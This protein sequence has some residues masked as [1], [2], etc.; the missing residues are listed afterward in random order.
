MIELNKEYSLP[1]PMFMA[2]RSED[3]GKWLCAKDYEEIGN[4]SIE[5]GQRVIMPLGV[6]EDYHIVKTWLVDPYDCILTAKK[7]RLLKTKYL[8][9]LIK[10]SV[11]NSQAVE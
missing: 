5:T 9:T 6:F 4:R 2:Y 1:M 3:D 10:N 7:T 8:K 11:L